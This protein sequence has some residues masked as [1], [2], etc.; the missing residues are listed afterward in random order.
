MYYDNS[1]L[2]C[3]TGTLT[4]PIVK[5]RNFL[6]WYQDFASKCVLNTHVP[7]QR[8]IP[9]NLIIQYDLTNICN[10]YIIS[11]YCEYWFTIHIVAASN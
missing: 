6:I 10:Y 7:T 2:M 3:I 11:P 8:C 4:E 9:Y 1:L 5:K